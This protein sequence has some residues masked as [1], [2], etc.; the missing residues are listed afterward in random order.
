M[1]LNTK[2]K[3]ETGQMD[4][5]FCSIPLFSPDKVSQHDLK[6]C[7][8]FSAIAGKEPAADP[9]SLGNKKESSADRKLG[10]VI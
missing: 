1:Q 2:Y 4:C 6:N 10:K 5:S 7:T 3:I 8:S 9:T